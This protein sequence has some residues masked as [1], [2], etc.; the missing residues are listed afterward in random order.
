VPSAST[1]SCVHISL[2]GILTHRY[3]CLYAKIQ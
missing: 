1:G 2:M 3:E